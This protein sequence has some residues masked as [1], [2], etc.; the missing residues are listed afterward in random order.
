MIDCKKSFP[1]TI[2]ATPASVCANGTSNN[3]TKSSDV[4]SQENLCKNHGI[5]TNNVRNTISDIT[6]ASDTV[7]MSVLPS[8]Y[9]RSTEVSNGKMDSKGLYWEVNGPGA[10][11]EC[12]C[13]TKEDMMTDLEK[14]QNPL[15]VQCEICKLWQHAKCVNYDL[16]DPYRG[17]FLCPHCHVS[18]PP[19]PSGA[20]L[21][22]TPNAISHQWVD[23]IFRHVREETLSVCVYTGVNKE[24]FV[25]PQ[26]LANQDIV[27]TTYEVLRK[28]IDYVDL[29]HSN[30]DS[31]RK[32]RR[33]KR[34][35]IYS[36]TSTHTKDG[37][38]GL[39]S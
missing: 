27:I 34:Y 12:L 5:D 33:P 30:S 4:D 35:V 9:G 39:S 28:E 29:P 36:Q 16:N 21:I 17:R 31:G 26:T 38:V 6:E 14:T 19:I 23:E 20:T 11:F 7:E 32:L 18:A 22:I 2:L 13:G 25:Q 24:G 1:E 37:L 3:D 10:S 15:I 8:S